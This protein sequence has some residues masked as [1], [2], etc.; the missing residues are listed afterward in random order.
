MRRGRDV[1]AIVAACT[2]GCHASLPSTPPI[3]R[4]M[5]FATEG[6]RD[7]PTTL[8]DRAPLLFTRRVEILPD[9][10][11]RVAVLKDADGKRLCALPCATLVP[12]S[13]GYEVWIRASESPLTRLDVPTVTAQPLLA[14]TRLIVHPQIGHRAGAVWMFIA[15]LIAVVM[16]PVVLA[17]ECAGATNGRGCPALVTVSLTPGVLLTGFGAGWMT[18]TRSASIEIVDE[19]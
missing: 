11:Y 9:D 2:L 16:L 6:A 3:D 13:S 10:K 5:S 18:Q 7:D 14:T 1:V 12:P 4:P 17:G 15:G 19:R 8:D